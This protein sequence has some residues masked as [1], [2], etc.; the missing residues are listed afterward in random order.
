MKK[1]YLDAGHGGQDSGAVSNGLLE[2]NLVLKL[3]QYM[4]QFLNNQYAGFTIRT[5][6]T[7]D[8]FLSLSERASRA[9]AWGADAFMSIHVNAGGGTGYED[10]IYT[11]RR[12]SSV[13]LRNA[14]HDEV[15]K[16]I[17]GYNHPNRGRKT[18]SYAVLRR[19]NMPAVLTEIAFIDRAADATLLKN[20]SFL[21]NIAYAY[22]KGMATFLN[23][24]TKSGAIPKPTPTPVPIPPKAPA[25]QQPAASQPSAPPASTSGDAVIRTIQQTLNSRY[26]T[27][28][29]VDGVYGPNTK[30]ALIKGL[31]SELNTQFNAGLAVDGIYGSNTRN[32]VVNVV[33]GARGNLTWIAQAALYI[34]GQNPGTIDG[35]FGINTLNAVKAF[36]RSKGLSSDGIIGTNTWRALF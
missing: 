34:S 30:A 29:A 36:Q 32:A 7:T 15:K 35:I 2:K 10:Y 6:R 27:G 31:Q 23:L 21:Q 26:K 33:E 5:T 24:P 1:I 19:T 22:A 9:N 13:S 16:I 28:I 17:S 18:A 25:P 14:V 11:G 8:V 20:E 12:V 3:Q 4:I